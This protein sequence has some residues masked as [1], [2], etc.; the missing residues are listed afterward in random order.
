MLHV[1][2]KGAAQAVPALV[3]GQVNVAISSLGALQSYAK[4]GRVRILAV[5]TLKRSALAP[6]VPTVAEAAG[7][8]DFSHAGGSGFVVRAGTSR[9]VIDRLHGALASA[10]PRPEV[11]ARF[12]TVGMEPS[13]DV[14]PAFLSERIRRDRVK[15]LRIVKSSGATAQ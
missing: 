6:E 11:V 13:P 15:Y 1:P 5:A 7:I 14:S 12:A 2:Y 9:A 10:A 8:P 3:G 4:E